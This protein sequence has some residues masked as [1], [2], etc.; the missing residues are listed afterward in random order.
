[1]EGIGKKLLLEYRDLPEPTPV[2]SFARGDHFNAASYPPGTIL[3]IE[4]EATS[5]HTILAPKGLPH[6]HRWTRLGVV[7]SIEKDPRVKNRRG[8]VHTIERPFRENEPGSE[9]HFYINTD[10]ADLT[11]GEVVHS[12]STLGG[13]ANRWGAL[14]L[15]K[16]E[17]INRIQ[18][19]KYGEGI[20]LP[21][22]AQLVGNPA[23]QT[24]Q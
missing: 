6:Y 4:E 19:L 5:P 12:R 14:K 9:R 24:S 23:R 1:M 3:R 2:K 20:L 10:W 15:E 7:V 18:I 16:I 22:H 13:I 8:I 21:A 11:V 17:R